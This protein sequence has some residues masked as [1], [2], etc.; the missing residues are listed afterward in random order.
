MSK[1][2]GN[3]NTLVNIQGAA[4]W[5]DLKTLLTRNLF[6]QKDEICLNRDLNMSGQKSHKSAQKFYDRCLNIFN[7]LCSYVNEH[8]IAEEAKT[9]ERALYQNID[10]KTFRYVQFKRSL[11]NNN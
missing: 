7:L 2:S 3:A 4:T 10:L 11:R 9:L 5:L 1:L 6:D 8:E